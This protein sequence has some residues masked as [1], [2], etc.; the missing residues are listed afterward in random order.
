MAG[1]LAGAALTDCRDSEVYLCG[2]GN[3]VFGFII[4]QTVGTGL[5]VYAA[6]R[7]VE[8]SGNFVLT[9]FGAGV[10]IAASIAILWEQASE[11]NSS[12][13]PVL[14]L[15]PPLGATLF[16]NLSRRYRTPPQGSGLINLDGDGFYVGIPA[17]SATRLADPHRTVARSV[18][19]FTA[20]W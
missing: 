8:V 17:L 14:F 19:L 20:S 3:A 16:N 1:A 4:G 15:G 12:V 2:L 7:T 13:W 11:A 10:G 9:M 6:G 18:R 5:I